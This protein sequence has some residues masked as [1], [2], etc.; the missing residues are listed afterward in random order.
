MKDADA[1]KCTSCLKP[2]GV[3]TR[4]HHCRLCG[5]VF[6]SHCCA[7]TER[8][9]GVRVCGPCLADDEEYER[10]M[11][12]ECAEEEERL[13]DMERDL[14]FEGV[15]DQS[16]G[17]HELNSHAAGDMV[18]GAPVDS[19][20][21]TKGMRS[22]LRD[23][24][25]QL[26]SDCR[27][28]VIEQQ[29]QELAFLTSLGTNELIALQEI[30][31]LHTLPSLIQLSDS[32]RVIQFDKTMRPENRSMVVDAEPPPPVSNATADADVPSITPTRSPPDLATS[33]ATQHL[34]GMLHI[35][36]PKLKGSKVS[37]GTSVR[38]DM[39]IANGQ[40]LKG[41]WYK[42]N[43]EALLGYVMVQSED[44][45]ITVSLSSR[46]GNALTDLVLDVANVVAQVEFKVS[47]LL[48]VE[49][50]REGLSVR[51]T[52]QYKG[53]Y[54]CPEVYGSS[55][56]K[57]LKEGKAMMIWSFD[58]RPVYGSMD[59]CSDCGRVTSKCSCHE[60][61]FVEPVFLGSSEPTDAAELPST[62]VAGERPTRS[63]IV[64]VER[65]Q[66]SEA[67]EKLV[68]CAAERMIL[69]KHFSIT[70][71]DQE[72]REAYGK[73][74]GDY[75]RATNNIF[76]R[77]ARRKRFPDIENG[78]QAIANEASRRVACVYLARWHQHGLVHGPERKLKRARDR[79]EERVGLMNARPLNPSVD[80]APVASKRK[81]TS[82]KCCSIM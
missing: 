19:S 11:V 32:L 16:S 36:I 25:I 40:P 62:K 42:L 48:T 76:Y 73:L 60:P 13:R 39:R 45:L 21:P 12:Q 15:S 17:G 34:C 59:F 9:G 38:V 72:Q 52:L 29:K 71:I 67:W 74:R 7:K 57:V 82:D 75:F 68:A 70:S 64:I 43:Q 8:Y 30:C 58:V 81:P 6:C 50:L 3:I 41:D 47:D 77:M 22:N 27:G 28:G 33:A 63:D 20:P 46:G 56:K 35:K 53:T 54:M 1:L 61:A 55:T 66:A 49:Q 5:K 10:A 51:E 2:F 26:E 80:T 44:D 14:L 65:A 78:L 31:E 37:D 79:L 4:R 18:D 69:E 23:V 24:L